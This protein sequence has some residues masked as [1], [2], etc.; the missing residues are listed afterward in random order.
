VDQASNQ[1]HKTGTRAV[2]A[3]GATTQQWAVLG[4]LSP[5]AQPRRR[6]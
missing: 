4:A 6:A 3:Q 5:A 2:A 1:L